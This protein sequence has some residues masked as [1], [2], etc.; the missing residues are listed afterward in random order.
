MEDGVVDGVVEEVE[1]EGL[2]DEK[3]VG[4]VDED[5]K[6]TV[7]EDVPVLRKIDL[8]IDL[9]KLLIPVLEKS[10]RISM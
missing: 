10:P 6:E 5:V 4:I 2:V 3:V 9:E 8:E 7:D 1:V